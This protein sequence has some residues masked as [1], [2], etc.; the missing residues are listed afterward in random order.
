MRKSIERKAKKA[1]Q[2]YLRV[3]EEKLFDIIMS[4]PVSNNTFSH[5]NGG[6]IPPR[7][8]APPVILLGQG[9]FTKQLTDDVSF[10]ALLD[11]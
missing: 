10:G 6:A 9:S 4:L 1:R 3:C 11:L 2:A 8:G 5:C 7:T